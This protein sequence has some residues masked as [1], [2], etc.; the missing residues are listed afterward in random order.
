[1]VQIFIFCL[2]MVAVLMQTWPSLLKKHCNTSYLMPIIIYVLIFV[3]MC[4]SCAIFVSWKLNFK[5]LNQMK[6]L[7]WHRQIYFCWQRRTSQ[8]QTWII[9]GWIQ[10]F[11]GKPRTVFEFIFMGR[12]TSFLELGP[13]G[14]K[15]HEHRRIV[16]T[17]LYLTSMC[18]CFGSHKKKRPKIFFHTIENSTQFGAGCVAMR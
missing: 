17:D 13:C 9:T 12:K 16:F 8:S 14:Q 5:S 10:T 7:I 15:L 18:I 2:W 6:L 4:I 1:M 3:Y 11:Q